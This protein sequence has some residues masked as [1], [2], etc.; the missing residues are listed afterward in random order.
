MSLGTIVSFHLVFCSYQLR[1]AS[2][3]MLVTIWSCKMIDNLGNYECYQIFNCSAV[4]IHRS[5]FCLVRWWLGV[6][7]SGGRLFRQDWPKSS[8]A[9]RLES[10]TFEAAPRPKQNSS[11]SHVLFLRNVIAEQHL[12][13]A[14]FNPILPGLLN[15]LQ[16]QGGVFYPPPNSLVFFLS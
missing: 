11:L 14:K 6:T 2:S 9:N 4:I 13:A 16:T 10:T 12:L 5:I 15:T 7:Q 1:L 3:R 8:E